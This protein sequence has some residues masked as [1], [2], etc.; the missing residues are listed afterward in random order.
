MLI[1]N[2]WPMLLCDVPMRVCGGHEAHALSARTRGDTREYLPWRGA[3][4]TVS[5]RI[6][7]RAG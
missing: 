7:V 6:Y 5:Q 4:K 3:A 2:M 1:F